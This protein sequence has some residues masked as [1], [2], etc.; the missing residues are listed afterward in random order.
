MRARILISSHNQFKSLT[1]VTIKM[2]KEAKTKEIMG[3]EFLAS[4]IYY[5]ERMGDLMQELLAKVGLLKGS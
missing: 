5:L 4:G 1:L 2:K 3:S